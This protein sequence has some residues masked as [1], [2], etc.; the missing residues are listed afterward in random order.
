MFSI[1]CDAGVV[2]DDSGP[3]YSNFGN[4]LLTP[5]FPKN[6]SIEIFKKKGDM[7]S[8]VVLNN[9]A[10]I[11]LQD[12]ESSCLKRSSADGWVECRLLGNDG[13]VKR[14]EFLSSKEYQPVETWPFRYWIYI[15]SEGHGEEATMLYMKVPNNP[16]LIAPK[17]FASVFFMV[18]FDEK[19][20]AI[21]AKTHKK[22][23]DRVFV[24]DNAVYLASADP[25]KR[26][27]TGWLFLNY[28]HAD[29]QALCPAKNPDSC[30]SAVNLSPD[31]KGIKEFYTSAKIPF[32]YDSNRQSKE[33]EAWYGKEMVAFG[34]HSDPILPLMYRVPV[35]VWMREDEGKN[36][37]RRIK[38]RETPFCLL[39]CKGILNS[40]TLNPRPG[41]Y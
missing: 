18:Y 9:V 40:I 13:W 41:N 30:Y 16:Y 2:I 32:F 23:G 22:T 5:I 25:L 38:N 28:F 15:A 10:A 39:D 20:F 11:N 27:K 29:F 19:G 6:K 26:E 12:A 31:W 3:S 14:S 24:V 8:V 1:L 4:D 33:K 21:S 36:D 34:V 35:D 17:Q 7:K 37:A